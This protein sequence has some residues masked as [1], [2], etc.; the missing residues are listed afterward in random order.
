MI[1]A[2]SDGY[3]GLQISL[4]W[5]IASL[6]LFQLLFGESMTT[7]VDA[8]EEGGAVSPQDQFLASSHYWVG[9]AVLGLVVIRLAVRLVA[10]APK[11]AGA[12]GWMS[13]AASVAH[14]LFYAL[15]VAVPVSGLLAFYVSG[16]IGD[17]HSL[18]K[19]AFIILI[20]LHAAA[21][22]L[23]QFVLKDGTLR[24]MLVPSR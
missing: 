17:I 22:F 15:L 5:I 4:H 18:G 20:L 1:D 19:P 3:S 14:W 2:R 6:V 21:A 9:L 8:A 7:V 16:D 13:T 10:G 23:H 12:T 24:R 11:A